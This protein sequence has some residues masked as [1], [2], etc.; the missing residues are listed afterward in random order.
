MKLIKNIIL[1]SFLI[2]LAIFFSHNQQTVE[3]TVPIVDIKISTTLAVFS[4]AALFLGALLGFASR[5]S[6]S[7]EYHL[8]EKKLRAEIKN[9]KT[10]KKIYE[11]ELN[12]QNQLLKNKIDH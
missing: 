2:S 11:S 9:L 1:I 7:R 10:Q 8:R 3:I 5:K 4:L 12:I 6:N